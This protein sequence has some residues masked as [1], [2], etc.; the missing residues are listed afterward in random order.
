MANADCTDAIQTTTYETSKIDDATLRLAAAMDVVK[1]IGIYQD[2]DGDIERPSDQIIGG[3]LFAARML[4]EDAY[5]AL[6][7]PLKAH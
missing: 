1:A 2:N 5:N 3:A 4:M 7:E 6:G